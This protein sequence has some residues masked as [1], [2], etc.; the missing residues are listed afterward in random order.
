VVIKVLFVCL[1]NI[2]RSPLAEGIFKEL[3]K[4]RGLT[5]NITCDSAGTSTY[6]IDENPDPRS[7][8]IALEHDIIL[9]HLGRQINSSDFNKFEYIVVMDTDNYEAI[10]LVSGYPHYKGEL[11]LMRKFDSLGRNENVPDPYFGADDG[12]KLV[13]DMLRRSCEEL[14]E[15]IVKK[16]QL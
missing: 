14:L 1:G 10:K 11:V 3:V 6:H 8:A 9:N 7:I 4:K 12:F 13:Y 2:C 16:H 5:Q 15:E